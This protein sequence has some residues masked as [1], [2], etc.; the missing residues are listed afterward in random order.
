MQTDVTLL[1]VT[2]C[3]RLHS[4]LHVCF[5]L[6]GVDAQSFKPVTVFI[7]LNT[8]AFIKFLAFPIPRLFEGGVYFEITFLNH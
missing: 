5:I 2:R 7:R 1:D 4:L 3:V 8:A 6:L